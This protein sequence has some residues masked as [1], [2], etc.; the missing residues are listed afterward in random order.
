MV[1]ERALHEDLSFPS[2]FTPTSLDE[3]VADLDL[4]FYPVPTEGFRAR[5][6][7]LTGLTVLCVTS[8]IHFFDTKL[9]SC[10]PR[11]SRLFLLSRRLAQLHHRH[12]R[13]PRATRLQ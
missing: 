6:G 1:L 7:I 9:T 4:A 2:T 5:W 3:L 13:L 11:F 10:S 12:A 8:R